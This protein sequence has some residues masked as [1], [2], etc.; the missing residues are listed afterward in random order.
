M[1]TRVAM[2]A[3]NWGE[4]FDWSLHRE[5][6]GTVVTGGNWDDGDNCSNRDGSYGF[7]RKKEAFKRAFTPHK[8]TKLSQNEDHI[9]HKILL[10]KP[11]WLFGKSSS[12]RTHNVLKLQQQTHELKPIT[13]TCNDTPD[14]PVNLAAATTAHAAAKINRLRGSVKHHFAAILIQTSF[15]G[16]LARRARRALK[17]IVMLQAV[18]RGQN[19]RKQ[20][21]I[22]LRCM[23]ALLRVQSQVHDQRYKLSNDESRKSMMSE[24]DS[25]WE[26]KYLQDIKRRKSMTRD[27]RCIADDW[28]DRPHNLEEL[29]AMLENRKIYNRNLSNMDDKELEETASWLD[30]RIRAKQWESRRTSRVSFEKRDS[31]KPIE[32]DTSTQS[33]H[34]CC[35]VYNQPFEAS[36]YIPNSPRRRSSYSPSIGQQPI[37]PSPVKTMKIQIRSASPRC[38]KEERSY[39]KANIQSLRLTPHAMGSMCRYSTCAN[40]MTIPNYMVATESAKAKIRSLS[41]PRYRPSTPER[42]GVGSVKKRLAFPVLDPCDNGCDNYN[43]QYCNY[44]HTLRSPSFKSV[45]VGEGHVGMGQQWY[46]EDS[47]TGGEFSPCSTTDLRSWLR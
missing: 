33:S 4:G 29:D 28:S 44:G 39:L 15:R 47:T 46:N 1:V 35:G 19:V 27:E 30:Q 41:T 17:G 5:A 7:G 3:T 24:N 2:E 42:E 13:S 32:I 6:I 25:F 22:T 21:V 9:D 11:R 8:S 31:I 16:Y 34:S 18:I 40:D 26:S 43:V 45:Q 12:T 38:L 20:A 37:T 23:Q 36:H 14:Q 10:H